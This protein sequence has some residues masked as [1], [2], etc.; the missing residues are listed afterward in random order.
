M[1][2]LRTTIQST[3]R[4]VSFDIDHLDF[5]ATTKEKVKEFIETATLGKLT[6]TQRGLANKQFLGGGESVDTNALRI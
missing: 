6:A 2:A 5:E 1:K 3:V 4:S